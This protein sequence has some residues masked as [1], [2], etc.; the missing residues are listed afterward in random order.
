MRLILPE[1]WAPTMRGCLDSEGFTVTETPDGG[2]VYPEIPEAQAASLELAR[3]VCALKHPVDP[4]Y[5][6]ELTEYQQQYL[7]EYFVYDLVPCLRSEGQDIS[8]PPGLQRFLETWN[9]EDAWSPYGEVNAGS[10]SDWY[11]LNE[12]CPQNP[13]DPFG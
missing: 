4:R 13:E 8:T 5:S 3:Y 10:D 1:E 6:G 12:T 9:T 7:Y 11:A 2:I